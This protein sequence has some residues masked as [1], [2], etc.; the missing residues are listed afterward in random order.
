MRGDLIRGQY[1]LRGSAI[2]GEATAVGSES[3]DQRLALLWHRQLCHRS[4]TEMRDR[5]IGMLEAASKDGSGH[6]MTL[7]DVYFPTV[8]GIFLRGGKEAFST[9]AAWRTRVK[10]QRRASVD[11]LRAGKW[12]GEMHEGCVC[13]PQ[14]GWHSALP[15]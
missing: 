6:G 1:L 2:A 9:I 4:E 11:H 8:W 5:D 12:V 15:H 7:R 14:Y 13:Y 3:C 10:G